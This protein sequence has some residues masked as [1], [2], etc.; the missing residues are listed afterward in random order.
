MGA[1]TRD[2]RNEEAKKLL[3]WG[4]SGYEIYAV[5]LQEL[6]PLRVLGGV[7]DSCRVEYPEFA[8][9]LPKGEASSVEMNMEI[10]DQLRAPI[11]AG[12]TV[13]CVKYCLGEQ[14]LGRVDIIAKETVE[15]INFG[16][17]FVRMLCYF[18]GKY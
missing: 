11:R 14:I 18:I 2:I 7:K 12:Q 13:G 10:P 15:K 1:P 3:D 6:S 4:F 8:C 5:P 17:L 9:V 16:G